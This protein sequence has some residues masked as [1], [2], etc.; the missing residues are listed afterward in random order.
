MNELSSRQL[1]ALGNGLSWPTFQA[2]V[3]EIAGDDQGTVQGAVTSAS[4]LASIVGLVLG[5]LLY[6]SLG[7]SLFLVAA[8]LFALTA[9]LTQVLFGRR[10]GSENGRGERI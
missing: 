2:R 4:S 1:F 7:S 10:G 8:A 5:G 9:A 3:A 6:P